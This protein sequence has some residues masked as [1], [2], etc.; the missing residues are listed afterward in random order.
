M[1]INPLLVDV[2]VES[3][4]TITDP[5][6]WVVVAVFLI[7]TAVSY[8][9]TRYARYAAAAAWTLFAG[10]WLLLTPH[11]AFVQKSFIE[12]ILSAVAVP[13]SL[14]VAYLVLR[15]RE[16]LLVLTRAVA[17]MGVL[18]LPALL[19]PWLQEW[20]I[21]TTTD[22]V[23]WLI[24]VL[25]HEPTI[26]AGEQGYQDTFL[27]WTGP[28]HR[29]LVQVILACTGIGSMSVVSGL[30]LAMDAPLRRKV[31]ALSIALPVIYLANIVRVAFIALAS[32]QQWFQVFVDEIMF[33]FGS[34]DVYE[35]SYYISD[36][37][38]AQSLSVVLLVGLVW[39]LLRILPELVVVVEDVLYIA[40]G[41]SYDL[42]EEFGP[43]V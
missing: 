28:D 36:R 22:N 2:S 5:L 40:T 6:A 19:L 4:Q 21:E 16:S 1:S 3:I 8:R 39:V 31:H 34:T 17:V 13:A 27:F 43:N 7:A 12:G 42:G 30:V 37:I 33:L 14:Y 25:G 10:F 9:S 23:A 35:V 38:I 26:I 11:F 32:G 20:L 15:K 24:T 29:F 18:Y 41:D